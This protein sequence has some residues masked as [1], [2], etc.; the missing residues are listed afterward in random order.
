MC[1]NNKI[2]CFTAKFLVFWTKKVFGPRTKKQEYI[3]TDGKR[4]SVLMTLINATQGVVFPWKRISLGDI[5]Q[6][7]NGAWL[8]L[9][10]HS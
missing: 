2:K 6:K 8:F 10:E 3:Y 5:I 7:K 9:G 1:R 4:V